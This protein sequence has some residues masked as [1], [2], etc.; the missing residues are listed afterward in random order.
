MELSPPPP[1][2]LEAGQDL[3]IPKSSFKGQKFI[4]GQQMLKVHIQTLEL[5]GLDRMQGF[6]AID[7]ATGIREYSALAPIIEIPEVQEIFRK[8]DAELHEGQIDPEVTK[9]YEEAKKYYARYRQTPKEEGNKKLRH[10]E[11][12]GVG[13]DT[14]VAFLPINAI[15]FFIQL[16]HGPI[17]NP[18]TGLLMFGIKGLNEFVE[19]KV[20]SGELPHPRDWKGTYH[21][22]AIGQETDEGPGLFDTLLNLGGSVIGFTFGGPAGAALGS[23]LANTASSLTRGHKIGPSLMS[24]LQGGATT[25][26]MHGLS[27]NGWG[28]SAPAASTAATSTNALIN[29]STGLMSRPAAAAARFTPVDVA[30]GFVKQAAP[31]SIFSSIGNSA[32]GKAFSGMGGWAN[33]GPLAM[34]GIGM[35]GERQKHKEDRKRH[36]EHEDKIARYQ[37]EMGYNRDLGPVRKARKVNPGY[38]DMDPEAYQAGHFPAAFLEDEEPGYFAKGGLVNRDRYSNLIKRNLTG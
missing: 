8:L 9:V 33:F 11:H 23:G 22:N 31:T 30:K 29:P 13:G 2:T 35:L 24:G 25:Y 18:K 16:R 26:A 32:I 36:R 14:K 3:G 27:G 38:F 20:S 21:F 1:W 6:E 28:F 10:F 5:Q 12:L 17:I 15:K 4:N 7:K 34:T 19:N 37:E